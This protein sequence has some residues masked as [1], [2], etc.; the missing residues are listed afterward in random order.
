MFLLMAQIDNDHRTV[1]YYR[2]V[3]CRMPIALKQKMPPI[4]IFYF[5]LA[6]NFRL[7]IYYNAPASRGLH[8]SDPSN[9]STPLGTSFPNLLDWLPILPSESSLSIYLSINCTTFDKL[10]NIWSLAQRTG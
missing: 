5:Y 4:Y 7:G 2:Q 10:R 6:L 1:C 3:Y 9:P 8:L